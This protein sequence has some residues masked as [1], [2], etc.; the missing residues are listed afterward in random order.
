MPWYDAAPAHG[1]STVQIPVTHESGDLHAGWARW[2]GD[3][4][5]TVA[6]EFTAPSMSGTTFAEAVRGETG[7]PAWIVDRLIRRLNPGI[8]H[9]DLR[10]HGFLVV[11]VTRDDLTAT[12]VHHDGTRVA[13]TLHSRG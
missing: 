12:F 9:V 7:L 1:R 8:D 6:H 5:G 11:D 4:D 10:R 3:G 2:L 13:R